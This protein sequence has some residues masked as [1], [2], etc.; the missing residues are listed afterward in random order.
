M[1]K[2]DLL[3]NELALI[4]KAKVNIVPIVMTWDGIVTNYHRKY[5]K[6]IG[7]TEN[8]HFSFTVSFHLIY[9]TDIFHI[10]ISCNKLLIELAAK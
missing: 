6:E 2:Y 7:I 9:Y 10:K 3:A 5:L 8:I 4:H 1:R